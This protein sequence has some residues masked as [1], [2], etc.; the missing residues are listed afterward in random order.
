L[1]VQKLLS[2]S[3]VLP[4]ESSSPKKLKENSVQK[5]PQH[6]LLAASS[7]SLPSSPLIVNYYRILSS[8]AG[9]LL[10][11]IAR[12]TA[13]IDCDERAN[14]KQK[15]HTQT[16]DTRKQKIPAV[17]TR[18]RFIARKNDLNCPFFGCFLLVFGL[19][20]CWYVSYVYRLQDPQKR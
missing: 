17:F 3:N 5:R 6:P 10:R 12:N 20:R 4:L 16:K 13:L 11:I 9:C 8:T 7:P 14:S 1:S 15:I 18:T 2:R 19:R